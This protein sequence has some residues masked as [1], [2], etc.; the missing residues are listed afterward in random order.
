MKKS[1]KITKIPSFASIKP[2]NET[3][4]YHFQAAIP[5]SLILK[6]SVENQKAKI[7]KENII[8]N[9]KI[10]LPLEQKNSKFFF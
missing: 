5:L 1:S 10:K 9:K 7:Q 6:Q 4:T 2:I 8:K 3:L